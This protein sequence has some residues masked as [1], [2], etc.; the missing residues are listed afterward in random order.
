MLFFEYQ[1]KDIGCPA[2][3]VTYEIIGEKIELGQKQ[4]NG[5][6]WSILGQYS[7]QPPYINVIGLPCRVRQQPEC[8]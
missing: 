7:F 5:P 6:V 8:R 2:R 4:R 3:L 1:S